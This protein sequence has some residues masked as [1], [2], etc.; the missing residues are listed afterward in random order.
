[1][2]KR[3]VIP[4]VDFMD[5]REMVRQREL[6]CMK[7]SKQKV[8]GFTLVELIVVIAII[9]VLAGI[10]VPTMLGFIKKA[11][12]ASVNAGAKSVL[13][14]GMTACRETDV[15]KP[16]PDGIYHSVSGGSASEDTADTI[17]GFMYQ[18][19]PQLADKCWAM[20]ITSDVVVAAC[21]AESPNATVIGTYPTPNTDDHGYEEGKALNF[22]ENGTWS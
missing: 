22:A 15:I 2:V 18:Y 7:R 17:K 6:I 4:I 12:F 16:I 11:R 3:E 9:G 8:K 14:A 21:Y 19:S 5:E 10:L 13:N 20:Q 1:M